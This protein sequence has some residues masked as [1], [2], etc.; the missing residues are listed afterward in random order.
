MHDK[1]KIQQERERPRR[2]DTVIEE[3]EEQARMSKEKK[4]QQER[5]VKEGKEYIKA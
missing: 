5:Q 2:I 1:E 3:M 4:E